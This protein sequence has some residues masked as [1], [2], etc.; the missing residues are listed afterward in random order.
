[1]LSGLGAFAALA[2]AAEQA[3][4]GAVLRRRIHTW[5]DSLRSLRFV[6]DLRD[7]CL[8]SLPWRTALESAPFVVDPFR[9]GPAPD[10][11]CRVLALAEAELPT[12]V[13]PSLL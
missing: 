8:P 5:F 4:V 9:A 1:V 3:P 13:G 11:V 10:A 2:S 7:R 6:H 12:Q